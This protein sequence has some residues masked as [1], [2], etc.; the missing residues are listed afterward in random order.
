M[1]P[2][3]RAFYLPLLRLSRQDTPC[4]LDTPQRRRLLS[5]ASPH[6]VENE[7]YCNTI[8]TAHFEH[9]SV[10]PMLLHCFHYARDDWW[11]G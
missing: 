4:Q 10:L 6:L 11:L 1:C 9:S 7:P 8:R 5:K 3:L 2:Y